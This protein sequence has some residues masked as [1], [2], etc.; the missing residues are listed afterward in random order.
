MNLIDFLATANAD[1]ETA[2]AEAHAF[3]LVKTV[4]I[5]GSKRKVAVETINI[6]NQTRDR[7]DGFVPDSQ[8]SE[9]DKTTA[10]GLARMVVKALDNLFNPEFYI[11]LDDPQVSGAYAMA[12]PLGVLSQAEYDGILKAGEERS[13]PFAN[14]TLTDIKAARNPAVLRDVV[15]E[16]NQVVLGD[17]AMSGNSAIGGF[18]FTLTP[19]EDFSGRIKVNVRAKRREETDFVEFP[20]IPIFIEGDF[21][22]G[23]AVSHAYQR[24]NS[25]I[26]YRHFKFTFEEPYANAV[27]EVTAEGI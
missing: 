24:T 4:R 11:R 8:L 12:V 25:L 16:A 15:V 1:D 5:E 23:V 10:S 7:L 18:R 27:T 3:E 20:Q 26:G 2:L 22:A 6:F 21:K 13:F 17:G 19:A 9:T 14:V